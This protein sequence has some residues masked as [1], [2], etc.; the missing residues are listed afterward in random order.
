MTKGVNPKRHRGRGGPP[1]VREPLRDLRTHQVELELQNEQLRSTQATLAAANERLA[2]LYDHAP[3]GYLTLDSRGKVVEANLRA[4][5]LL[6]TSRL[7]LLGRRLLNLVERESKDVLHNHIRSVFAGG[8]MQA[9]E[10]AFHA[11]GGGRLVALVES[12]AC[13]DPARG[14]RQCRSALVDVTERRQAEALRTALAAIERVIHSTLRRDAIMQ[15]ALE[16][17]AAALSCDSAAISLRRGDRWIAGYVTGLPRGTVGLETTD[18]EE[19]HAVL[20]AERRAPVAVDDAWTE[21]RVK[22]ARM[23]KRGTRSVLVVPLVV[24]AEAIGVISFNHEKA[25][26]VFGEIH[27]FFGAQL[28]ASLSLALENARLVESLENEVQEGRAREQRIAR[29]SRLYAVLSRVNEAIV[30]TRDEGTLFAEVCRTVAEQGGFPLVLVARRADGRPELAVACGPAAGGA[31]ASWAG[32]APEA[33]PTAACMAEDR[34]I[35]ARAPSL[36]L[37]AARLGF[38]SCAAFP[39]RQ[40]GAVA[41]ALT[42]CASDPDAFHGDDVRLLEALAADLSYALD[43]IQD[44]RLRAAAE[45]ALGHSDRRMSV[46]VDAIAD[47][48]CALDRDLRFTHVNDA[49]VRHFLRPREEMVGRLLT[50]VFPTARGTLFESEYRRALESGEPVHFETPSLVSDRT[51]EVHAYPGPESLTVL[52]HDATERW[53]LQASLQ[54]SEALYR[55]IARNLPD[56]AVT[57]VDPDLRCLVAEG[58]LV[59]L[60]GFARERVEGRPLTEALAQLPEDAA[61]SRIEGVFRRALAGEATANETLLS[62]RALFTHCAPLRDAANRITGAMALTL[63]V[64]ERVRMQRELRDLN[65]GL[66]RL[67]H[68]RTIALQESVA[69][70]QEEVT[71]RRRAEEELRATRDALERRAAQLHALAL[72]LTWA[73]ERERRRVAELMHADLQQLI[74]GASMRVKMLDQPMGPDERARALERA[75]SVLDEAFR[76]SRSLSHD[77]SPPALHSRCLRD[78]FAGLGESMAERHGLKVEVKVAPDLEVES[79]RARTLVY[80]A[81]QELLFNVVKHAGTREAE[82]S[83]ERAADHLRVTVA[84]TGRGFEATRTAENAGAGSGLAG[85]RERVG[86]LGGS[87]EIESSAGAGSR[88]TLRLPLRETEAPPPGPSTASSEPT[89][90][91][92]PPARASEGLPLAGRPVGVVIADDHDVVRQGLAALLE[93]EPDLRVVGEARNGIEAVEMAARLKPDVVILDVTMPEMDGVEATRRIRERHPEIDVIGLS[94]LDESQVGSRLKAAGASAFVSKAASSQKLLE[95]IRSVVTTRPG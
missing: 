64:T 39:L 56:A 61:R 38:R 58:S 85:I 12:L 35:I 65:E 77:L 44:E 40:A 81:V 25:P 20:A 14:V 86:L 49:A 18:A 84:D 3:V 11:P 71:R 76:A 4:A 16:M 1:A 57:V 95:A 5:A 88:V 66:E 50:D 30:R 43:A 92:T 47:G 52:F 29:L 28:A 31:E 55:A 33:S 53:A 10:L 42:I 90:R 82:V 19:P 60:F 45:L 62:G 21:S 68:E 46:I 37:A 87:L 7:D 75:A 89:P 79:D 26:F 93:G 32:G 54:R 34:S 83:A 73:E 72:E 6:G 91:A 41:G 69:R 22:R 94:M 24:R 9:C 15:G 70:L 59:P 36:S 23:R 63:D 80:R 67:V 74:L 78:A 2:D 51:I 8:G 17:A 48:F 27:R 13:E